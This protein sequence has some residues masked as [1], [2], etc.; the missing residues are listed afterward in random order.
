MYANVG[1]RS[2]TLVHAK[3]A[4]YPVCRHGRNVDL[5]VIKRRLVALGFTT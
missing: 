4:I 3:Y 5:D 1:V 2:L